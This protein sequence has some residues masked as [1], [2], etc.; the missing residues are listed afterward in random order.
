[1]ILPMTILKWINK[2]RQISWL[3]ACVCLVMIVENMGLSML[4]GNI[5]PLGFIVIWRIGKNHK[6]VIRA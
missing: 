2:H 5:Y 1:M 3:F 6:E 4:I